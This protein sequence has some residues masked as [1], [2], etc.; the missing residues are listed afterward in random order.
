MFIFFIILK[1]HS[2]FTLLEMTRVNFDHTIFF[3]YTISKVIFNPFLELTIK[4]KN[5]NQ[6]VLVI[7]FPI[8]YITS[9]WCLII[10]STHL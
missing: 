9:E 3:I 7:P 10:S 5:A 4:I 2:R 1:K 6:L 8:L